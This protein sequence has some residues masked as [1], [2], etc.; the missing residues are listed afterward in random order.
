MVTSLRMCLKEFW[1]EDNR[2]N[3]CRI[4][5]YRYSNTESSR[6]VRDSKPGRYLDV[7]PVHRI[8]SELPLPPFPHAACLSRVDELP[9]LRTTIVSFNKSSSGT[10]FFGM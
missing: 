8:V 5:P 4:T 1:D 3:S 6:V 9:S 2:P 7:F 10:L